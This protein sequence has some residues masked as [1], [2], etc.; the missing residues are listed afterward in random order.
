MIKGL[1]K[2]LILSCALAFLL[3]SVASADRY[4][5]RFAGA[6]RYETAIEI[7][8]NYFGKSYA[9]QAVLAPGNDFRTA[10]YGSYMATALKAPFYIVPKSGISKSI[11]NRLKINDVDRVYIMGD[12]KLLNNSLEKT[13][14]ANGFKY[15]RFYDRYEGKDF[16]SIANDMDLTLFS[17]LFP[18]IHFRGDLSNGILVNDQKFPDLLSSIPF[19]ANLMRE[20]GTCFVGSYKLNMND[21]LEGWRFIIGGN[22][23]IPKKVKTYPGDLDGL[24][25]HDK[26]Y[27]GKGSDLYTGRI[28]GPDRYKTAVE[29]AKAYKTVLKPYINTAVI[30]DST[31]YPDALASGTV[32]NFSN[33]VII[34]TRPD[35]LNEDTKAFIQ[36]ND[37]KNIIIVGG[38]KSVSKEVENELKGL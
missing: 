3:P 34:L 24:N 6:D 11:L 36:A 17:I 22:D 26:D 37:I 23:S 5:T 8:E 19:V 21:N 29:I 12:Y 31:N 1:K 7:Q 16:L 13:L 38:E 30:V 10:L 15:S 2:S 4:V 33:G 18:D 14:K 25:T 35:K 28:S 27:F 9:S 20:Q 32:A